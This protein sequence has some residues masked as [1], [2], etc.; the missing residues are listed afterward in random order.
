M[1]YIERC[2]PCNARIMEL[3][4]DGLIEQMQARKTE[5]LFS[6]AKATCFGNAFMSGLFAAIYWQQVN[7]ELLLLWLSSVAIILLRR[8]QLANRFARRNRYSL[9]TNWQK[10][11][12]KSS[13]AN[14]A[15]WGAM[16]LYT[17]ATLST[18]SLT[19]F[20]AIL[21][22]LVACSNVAYNSSLGTYLRFVLPALLPAFIYMALFGY[23][24]KLVLTAIATSWFV[25]M[26]SFAKQLNAHVAVT[27]GYEAHNLQL[28]RELDALRRASAGLQQEI[29]LKTRVIDRLAADI[30][31]VGFN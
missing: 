28:L 2:L 17:S 7:H 13:F 25:L 4:E 15:T 31:Q 3:K 8:W 22:A 14:G 21:G 23:A 29:A 20:I 30:R 18:Q 10:A 12:D 27:T 24:D 9:S 11:Y 5:F 1:K 26:Y 6:Q 16:F 19:G